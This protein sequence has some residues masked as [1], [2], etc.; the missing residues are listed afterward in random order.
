VLFADLGLMP[1]AKFDPVLPVAR[2]SYREVKCLNITD[3]V[4]KGNPNSRRVE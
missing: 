1:T 4:Y 3:K 2:G